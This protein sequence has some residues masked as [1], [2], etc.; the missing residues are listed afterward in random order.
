MISLEFSFV[1]QNIGQSFDSA[2]T[3]LGRPRKISERALLAQELAQ[4]TDPRGKEGAFFMR[5]LND[6]KMPH[7]FHAGISIS[8]LTSTMTFGLLL[9]PCAAAEEEEKVA[10]ASK[11]NEDGQRNFYDVLEDLLADFEY[12]L[13]NGDVQ[14]LKDLSIRNIALSENIPPSFRGHIELVITERILKTSRAKVIQCLA[15]RS[16]KTQVNGDQVIITSA[17][18]NPVEMAR[19]AKTAGISNFMDVAFT[20]Q[21]GGMVLS[22]T[23][24][25]PETGSVVWS[26]SYN[27][28]TSRTAAYRRGVDFSQIDDARRASEYRPTIQYRLTT[29]YAYQADVSAP[30]GCLGAG[31]RM[32]ERYDNRRKEV[33]FEIDSFFNSNFIAGGATTTTTTTTSLWTG[34]NLTL[35]FVHAW[36][37]IGLEE[38][39]NAAR[40][41]LFTAIGGTYASGYLG[42]LVRAGYEF[43]LAR[44]WAVSASM[45][46]RPP[47]ALFVG[48][49]GS[50][51]T[52]SGIEA[53]L[54]I[55]YLF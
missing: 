39:F 51:T 1:T 27:S 21:P 5:R 55:N 25:D 8:L 18:T 36:N 42:G 24:N 31:F 2:G 22:M 32:M 13:K 23:T 40:G 10:P 53:G 47:S 16:K 9:H 3:T 20:Y 38:N 48:T 45:G 44:H 12:D 17:D 50:S 46:Y 15:C 4:H 41:S 29:L 35:L 28:E 14:G 7:W 6:K 49:T 43:R 34:L 52:F 37:F 30:S 26:R 11:V 54:G 19:I 33:G